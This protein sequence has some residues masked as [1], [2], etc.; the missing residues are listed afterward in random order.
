MIPLRNRFVNDGT[1][2]NRVTFKH[3]D[4]CEK[5][6]KDTRRDETGDATADHHSLLT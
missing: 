3:G 5:I 2:F 4:V 1:V 6:S